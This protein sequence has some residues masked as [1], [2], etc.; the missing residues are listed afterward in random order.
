MTTPPLQQGQ[1]L[2]VAGFATAQQQPEGFVQRLDGSQG[3]QACRGPGG[4]GEQGEV[5]RQQQGA[6]L[7]QGQPL[8]GIAGGTAVQGQTGLAGE[9]GVQ[10]GAMGSRRQQVASGQAA[11]HGRRGVPASIGRPLG[12]C[13]G[14]SPGPAAELMEKQ[15]RPL[16]QTDRLQPG[17]QGIGQWWRLTG[18]RVGAG[19]S[20][21]QQHQVQLAGQQPQTPLARRME[22]Q[23]GGGVGSEGT[24]QGEVQGIAAQAQAMALWGG[25]EGAGPVDGPCSRSGWVGSG[26]RLSIAQ[27]I[28]SG[29]RISDE[30]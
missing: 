12:C 14:P 19:A 7:Q 6:Q 5:G 25:L 26:T 23:L 15:Q 18:G 4:E 20:H 1:Q 27:D 9:G 11:G 30:T 24:E 8:R 13:R 28:L 3:V 2:G 10:Q 16:A 29:E 21:A 17:C 22:C